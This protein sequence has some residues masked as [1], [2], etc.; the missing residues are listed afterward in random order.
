MQTVSQNFL[1]RRS[2]FARL[3]VVILDAWP[4][5]RTTRVNDHEL[6]ERKTA[7]RQ[8]CATAVERHRSSAS[9]R[10]VAGARRSLGAFV[11]RFALNFAFDQ[12]QH[13]GGCTAA[14]LPIFGAA[15]VASR[16]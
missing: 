15:R 16:Q 1:R 7:T 6:A 9:K 3:T 14:G 13:R 2:D 10:P 12:G 4:F 11:Q 5:L 8:R